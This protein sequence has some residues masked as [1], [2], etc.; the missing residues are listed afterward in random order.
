M[1]NYGPNIST[2]NVGKDIQVLAIV[3]TRQLEQNEF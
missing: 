1:G 2:N 3:S